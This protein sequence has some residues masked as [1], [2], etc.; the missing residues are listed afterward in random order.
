M[1]RPN[2]VLIVDDQH[3][4]DCLGIAG[5]PDVKTPY[6][7]SLAAKGVLFNNAYS[8]CPTCIPA[9]AALLTGM[10]QENHKRV[11]YEDGVAWQYE[12]TLAGELTKAGYYTQ[13]VGKM[14]VSPLRNLLGFHHVE[15]HD[16]YL[17]HNRYA[18][19]PYYENQKIADDYFYW[20]KEQKGVSCDVTNTG[21]ECNSW[22]AR[23]WMYDEALHPTN[24]AVDRSLDFLRRRDRSKPFF[25]MTSFVRPHPPFDAPQCYFDMY[26]NKELRPPY[27][28]EWADQETYKTKGRIYDSAEGIADPELI[29]EAQVGYYACITHI[30][31]QIGRLI[32][33]I[34]E[35]EIDDNTIFL[36]V[37]DHGELLGDHHM[38]RKTRP[39]KGSVQIPFILSGPNHLVPANGKVASQLVELR[40]VMPTLIDF[41]G[42]EIPADVDGKSV[43]AMAEDTEKAWRTYIHGEHSGGKMGN[44]YIVTEDAKYIWYT[45]S[46]EEQFFDLQQD[47]YELVNEIA[48]PCYE[49][50]IE[51]LRNILI[52]ELKDRPEG[53]SDGKALKSGCT[54]RTILNEKPPKA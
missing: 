47:P 30:D 3:R 34:I 10:A 42:G 12:H 35:E 32:Q 4:G 37:S 7:D 16:G 17:H 24:W 11:G 49:E 41:A 22:V 8:A 29:T 26:K 43:R 18:S 14:H 44:Q 39:Y 6:L 13:C 1:N 15:L 51:V 38:C 21:L 23:P 27:V 53:Y 45:Q 33:A 20:L 31:H 28:G 25:L 2:I 5:H 40:D 50:R 19:T 52:G 9:R 46:G 36:F 48:N 54:E